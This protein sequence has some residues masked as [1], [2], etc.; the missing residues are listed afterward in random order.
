[1]GNRNRIQQLEER[2][3]EYFFIGIYSISGLKATGYRISYNKLKT[4]LACQ[5]HFVR[6]TEVF[7]DMISMIIITAVWEYLSFIYSDL[8]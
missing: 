8:Y 4:V 6:I 1:M 5:T 2:G 7:C 3:D